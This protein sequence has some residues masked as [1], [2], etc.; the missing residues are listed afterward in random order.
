ME[1]TLLTREEVQG[2]QKLED[3]E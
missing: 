2:S 3:F 1:L